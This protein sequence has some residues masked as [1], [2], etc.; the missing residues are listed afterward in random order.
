MMTSYGPAPSHST[1][2]PKPRFESR[3]IRFIPTSI[4]TTTNESIL[5]CVVCSGNHSIE[6][7]EEFMG[8]DPAGR[9][10]LM[11]ERVR[12]FRCLCV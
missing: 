4:H 12:C 10:T 2:K 11:K 9:A 1:E 3:Q 7:C 8:R 6:I 5:K